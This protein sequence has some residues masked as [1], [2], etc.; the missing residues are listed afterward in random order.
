MDCLVKDPIIYPTI[1]KILSSM[2]ANEETSTIVHPA[3]FMHQD[4]KFV[5]DFNISGERVI[6]VDIKIHRLEKVEDLYKDET[7]FY[8]TLKKGFGSASPRTDYI[9][10]LVVKVWID[11]DLKFEHGEG[12]CAT[13]DMEM[14]TMPPV[15]RK[16]VQLMKPEEI[17]E[18]KTTRRDKLHG[19]F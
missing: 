6:K 13:F 1:R 7:T 11:G 18:M 8:K 19:F 12:Q 2:K 14:F 9:I 5:E 16:M 10:S 17:I 4:K 15:I 3:Y